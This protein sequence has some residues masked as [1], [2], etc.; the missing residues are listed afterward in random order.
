M[1]VAVPVGAS[2]SSE[3]PNLRAVLSLYQLDSMIL[4]VFSNLNI[5]GS[6]SRFLVSGAGVRGP[7]SPRVC[8]GKDCSDGKAL[9]LAGKVKAFG[10]DLKENK[11]GLVSGYPIAP[12]R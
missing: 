9:S 2:L 12:C 6:V 1:S 10:T 5:S 3:N 4:E 11:Q 7:L 8:Q